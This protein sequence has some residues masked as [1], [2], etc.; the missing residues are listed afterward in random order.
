ANSA[1]PWC[2][3][4]SRRSRRTWRGKAPGPSRRWAGPVSPRLAVPPAVPSPHAP[5]P[6]WVT[7]S[8]GAV[9][10]VWGRSGEGPRWGVIEGADRGNIVFGVPPL[11]VA[12]L[13]R[14]D[15]PALFESFQSGGAD[16]HLVG[17]ISNA[18]TSSP[19]ASLPRPFWVI[20]GHSRP[21]A[22][23]SHAAAWPC[24]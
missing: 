10:R 2:R 3:S 8:C 21:R 16:P 7:A 4:M 14:V 1:C 6:P 11:P 13:L 19:D 23:R 12:I 20:R 22:A 15:Q 24:P 9:G 17:R 18:H 5:A